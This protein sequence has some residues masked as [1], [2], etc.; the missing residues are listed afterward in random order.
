[1]L[2]NWGFLMEENVVVV[3]FNVLD[4]IVL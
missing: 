1:M 2:E 4:F 3:A